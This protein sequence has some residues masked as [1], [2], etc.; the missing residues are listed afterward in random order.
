MTFASLTLEEILQFIKN[1]EG[2]IKTIKKS[3]ILIFAILRLRK[4]RNY[5]FVY[6]KEKK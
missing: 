4:F 1:W 2:V 3:N 6:E 5:N